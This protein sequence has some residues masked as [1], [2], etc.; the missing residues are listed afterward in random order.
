[1]GVHFSIIFVPNG[2]H[3][4]SI[5]APRLTSNASLAYFSQIGKR[6]Q[7]HSFPEPRKIAKVGPHV[8]FIQGFIRISAPIYVDS[9][10]KITI[11]GCLPKIIFPQMVIGWARF[12]KASKGGT[13]NCLLRFFG[14]FSVERK[15]PTATQKHPSPE[16][17]EPPQGGHMWLLYKD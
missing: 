16:P 17:P 9:V 12:T 8:A 4:G 7:N 14:E 10:P 5:F 15:R 1:M 13:N 11:L 3:M 2:D 6:Q